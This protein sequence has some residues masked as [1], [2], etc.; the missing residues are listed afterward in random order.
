VAAVSTSSVRATTS[1]GPPS[2]SSIAEVTPCG[3]PSMP[4]LVAA[5]RGR[6]TAV[7]ASRPMFR[8][9]NAAQRAAREQLLGS[10]AHAL[11]TS[12]G[13][14]SRHGVRRQVVLEPH[15]AG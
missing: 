15:R 13:R 10:R 2:S 12:A 6:A 9:A 8:Q 11:G 4:S 5:P 3:C 1:S 14:R 7:R